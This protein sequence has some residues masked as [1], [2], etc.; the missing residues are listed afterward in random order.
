MRQRMEQNGGGIPQNQDK[1]LRLL[2]AARTALFL[3]DDMSAL[4]WRLFPDEILA[5]TEGQERKIAAL[6]SRALDEEEEGNSA[7]KQ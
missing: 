2:Q 7:T 4:M 5:L 3:L 1:A 6:L